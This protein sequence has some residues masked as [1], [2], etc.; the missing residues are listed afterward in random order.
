MK[1]A[2]AKVIDT[3]TQEDFH[4]VFE[5]LKI[6]F[7]ISNFF[8]GL[9][10]MISKYQK[11]K[12]CLENVWNGTISA[13]QPEGITSKVTRSFMCVL[14][15]NV[16]I[17]K[18]SGNL[19]RAPCMLKIL[20]KNDKFITLLKNIHSYLK[21]NIMLACESYGQTFIVLVYWKC[22]SVYIYI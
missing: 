1:E 17:R 6:Y 18:K 12:K 21:H 2:V 4:G 22:F 10:S 11:R 3:L 19:S 14:S 13:L 5:K 20:L 7:F 8:Y 16:P 9:I 15:I